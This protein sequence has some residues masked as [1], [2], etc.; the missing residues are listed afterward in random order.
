VAIS[1][2]MLMMADMRRLMVVAPHADD[3]ELGAGGYMARTIEDGG[4][5]MVV[6]LAVGPVFFHHLGRVVSAEERLAEMEAALR[7]LGVRDHAVFS[8]ET[9]GRLD[10]VPTFEVVQY[11]DA[12]QRE[13]RPTELLIPLP[14]SHQGH[15]AAH[16]AS[17]A[18]SRPR[19]HGPELVAAYEYPASSWGEGSGADPGR[20]GL[21]VE[22]SPWIERKLD[23]L[24]EHKSQMRNDGH[25]FSIRAAEALAVMRGLESGLEAELFH[26]MRQLMR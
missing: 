4:E 22:I 17:I 10:T 2:R 25:C 26:V 9:D 6:V 21:Y 8:K 18:A 19:S 24:R 15:A 1:M 20:G 16:W 7:I 12:L 11:L 3:A 23:A 13:F 14:S 5:V